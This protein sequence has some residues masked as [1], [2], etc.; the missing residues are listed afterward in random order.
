LSAP[1]DALLSRRD[2][3][4]VAALGAAGIRAFGRANEPVVEDLV[5]V[6]TYTT[7]GRSKGIYLLMMARQTGA[8]RVVG[9][10]AETTEPSFLTLAPG[11]PFVYAVNETTEYEGKPSG[12]ISAFIRDRGTGALTFIN[13]LPTGGGAPCYVSLD[14]TSKFV[15]VANYVGGS[16]AVFSRGKDGGMADMTSFVQH[17]GHGPDADR[18][19]SPHAHCI[20]PD[21]SNRFVLVAD[22]GLDRVFVYG[23][24]AKSGKLSAAPVTEA[25][26]ASGAGPRHLA[27]H[28][29]GRILYVVNELDSTVST[30]RYDKGTGKLTILQTVPSVS[31]PVIGRNAP[32]D[33]HVHPS[34]RFLYMSNRG[35]DSIAAFAIDK[36]THTLRPLQL[37]ATG[38]KWPRNFAID[39]S[40]R[41]LFVANQRSNSIVTH[42]INA[43]TGKLTPTGGSV[44]LPAP[45]CIRFAPRA[46][47][48]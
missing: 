45:V 36:S 4:A 34:G 13:K 43:A 35:H 14:G 25:V 7:D 24:D 22:L 2:F 5:Y 6:G 38:G 20:M 29:N 28:P 26:M 21:P 27:F 1:T 16:V 37:E 41:F 10:A 48:A 3:L 8:L 32:A 33:V 18:Q 30:L 19:S 47:H 39:P 31:E 44:E 42:R 23:F 9:P 46:P 11:G 17:V 40:G 12:A 15:L